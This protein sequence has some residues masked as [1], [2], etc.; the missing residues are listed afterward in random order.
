[1]NENFFGMVIVSNK[2]M[3]GDLHIHPKGC[4][5]EIEIDKIFKRSEEMKIDTIGLIGDHS[6]SGLKK[7][8]SFAEKHRIKTLYGVEMYVFC[9]E[10]GFLLVL[11]TSHLSALVPFEKIIDTS[12]KNFL[13]GLKLYLEY[14]KDYFRNS[15]VERIFNN[16]F[17]SPYALPNDFFI[18]LSN[19]GANV[20]FFVNDFFEWINR[21]PIKKNLDNPVM[22]EDV[23]EKIGD[24][25]I[26]PVV[27]APGKNFRNYSYDFIINFLEKVLNFGISGIEVWSPYNVKSL[28]STLL[29]FVEDKG[30]LATGGGDITF[31]DDIFRIGYYPCPDMY[32]SKFLT[33]SSEEQEIEL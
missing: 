29:K 12:R 15:D 4:G 23:V 20:K 27:V 10:T 22:L 31:G 16:I 19:K 24:Q 17:S 7:I 32:L 26:L 2:N 28:T 1:M 14:Q 11:Y 30:I 25:K 9:E 18:Q 6:F 21:Y 33:A 5:G 13:K 3:I 8:S